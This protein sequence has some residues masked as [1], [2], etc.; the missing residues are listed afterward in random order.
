MKK[1]FLKTHFKPLLL[2]LLL[3]LPFLMLSCSFLGSITGNLQLSIGTSMSPKTLLPTIPESLTYVISFS[4]P[5]AQ[6]PISTT[7]KSQTVMLFHGTWEISVE[8]RDASDNLI[9][10]GRKAD[11]DVVG[12]QVSAV[13]ID[14]QPVD[15]GTG[16]IDI[17]ISW[18]V[19]VSVITTDI[20]VLL[21]SVAVDTSTI[22][23]G[24]SSVSFLTTISSGKYLL[25]IK[26]PTGILDPTTVSELVFVF[27]NLTTSAVIVLGEDDF[28]SVPEAPTALQVQADTTSAILSWT[29]NSHV[30]TGFV[31]ERSEISC[32]YSAPVINEI[33]AGIS[34]FV[35]TTVEFGI[36]YYYRVKAINTLGESVYSN[37]VSFI[38]SGQL[39]LI[40]IVYN[41][42]DVPIAFTQLNDV[43]VAKGTTLS[44]GT[45]DVFEAYRWIL[46]GNDVG[47]VQTVDI[48][49]SLI[50]PGVHHIT[51]VVT[52]SGSLYS[53]SLR[54]FVE[55]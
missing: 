4:G 21:N 10:S 5:A 48:D 37:E 7:S 33:A 50:E 38:I 54:F 15:F 13:S 20:E 26:L 30:E 53:N 52:S 34:T 1:T 29:D 19:S 16:V 46:D 41:P 51:V 36:T 31:L 12:G 9:V 45:T 43:A 11:I 47:S 6:D 28:T 3:I 35:D 44:I 17:S 55:N 24:D 23:Y 18:P 14:V 40:I 22:T 42:E 25:Q 39:G 2:S 32:D 27:G 49:T 8:G